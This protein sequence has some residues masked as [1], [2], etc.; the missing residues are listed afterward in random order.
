MA[1][2]IF[3]AIQKKRPFIK[4]EGGEGKRLTITNN[5]DYFKLKEV[6][7]LLWLVID[8]WKSG[9]YVFCFYEISWKLGIFYK[10][11]ALFD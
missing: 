1:T 2:N 4:R 11:I 10:V 3:L 8:F 5:V 7:G 9:S 6:I